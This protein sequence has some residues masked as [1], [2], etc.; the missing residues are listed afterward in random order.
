MMVCSSII[1]FWKN[2]LSH[3]AVEIQ[4]TSYNFLLVGLQR[5]TSGLPHA[6]FLSQDLPSQGVRWNCLGRFWTR[7]H[8]IAL[9]FS[10]HPRFRFQEGEHGVLAKRISLRATQILFPSVVCRP[11]SCDCQTSFYY[12]KKTVCDAYH[13]CSLNPVTIQPAVDPNHP[14]AAPPS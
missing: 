6:I 1:S 4:H 9:R 10:I 13:N 12:R 7:R 8:T 3:S 2:L 5:W 11:G 14:P